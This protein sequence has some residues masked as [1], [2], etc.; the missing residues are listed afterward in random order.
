MSNPICLS[1]L[2]FY[3]SLKKQEHYKSYAFGQIS[4]LITKANFIPPFQ[5]NYDLSLNLV[6]AK[7][8][9]LKNDSEI[10][11]LEIVNRGSFF[12]NNCFQYLGNYSVLNTT[13]EG[14][15]YIVLGFNNN[16]YLY[17]EVICFRHSIDD[18]LEIEY[19]NPEA[20]FEIKGG[21]I[22]FAHNFHFKLFL[23]SELGKPNYEFEEEATNRFGYSF[24]ESQVSKK[25]YNFNA[26]LPE[27]LCDA[28]RII[29]LCSNKIITSKNETFDMITFNMEVDWQDQGNLASVNCEFE[30]DNIIVNLGGIRT[31]NLGGDFN[32]DFNNDYK[33]D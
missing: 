31:E 30:T 33:K 26:I 1:P 11:I 9:P 17:S 13:V 21:N 27:Y 3:D 19:W 20:D 15:Y 28:L 8:I 29:R 4:P 7:L 12:E 22:S 16:S 24:I 10:D 2:K 25:V 14:E 18:C 6:S 23:D 32:N 5:F